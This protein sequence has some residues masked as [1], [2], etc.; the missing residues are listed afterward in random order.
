VDASCLAIGVPADERPFAAH[1]TIGRV[2]S[3]RGRAELAARIRDAGWRPPAAW[4][5]TSMTL[6]RS[7]LSA[8]GPTYLSL[9]DIPLTG[10]S[11]AS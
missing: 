5:A 10:L 11:A 3:G 9:A 6:F 8:S 7:V 1:V 4:T 2:R